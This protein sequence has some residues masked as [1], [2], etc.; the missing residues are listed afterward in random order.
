MSPC[1]KYRDCL[2]CTEQVCVKGDAAR[3]ARIRARVEQVQACCDTARKEMERG[4]AGADRWLEYN[5]KTLARGRELVALLE[6]DEV[7]DGALI[8]LKDAA[9]HSHLGRALD[10]QLPTPRKSALSEKLQGLLR[11]YAYA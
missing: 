7:E 9:E 10:Q 5:L 1:D 3:Y 8:K 4:T 11:E 2:N 6:S